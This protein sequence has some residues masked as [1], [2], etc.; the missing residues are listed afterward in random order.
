MPR[1]V[2]FLRAI[3]VGGHTVKMEQLR[4]L[5]EELGFSDVETFIASGNVIFTARAAEPSAIERKIERHLEAALGYAVATFVRTVDEVSAIAGREVFASARDGSGKVTEYVILL[6]RPLP[7]D[8]REQVLS[9]KT[10]ADDFAIDGRE[11]YWRRAG[12]MLESPFAKA[13]IKDVGAGTMRNRNT[14]VRLAARCEPRPLR[15]SATSRRGR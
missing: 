9:F 7:P 11:I 15:T 10:D 5:F 13:A 4:R 14:L 6:A 8:G 3:N 1:Y 2:A 12:S